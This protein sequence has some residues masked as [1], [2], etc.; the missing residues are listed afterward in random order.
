MF[1]CTI[2]IDTIYTHMLQFIGPDSCGLRFIR[3][4]NYFVYFFCLKV[5]F[6]WHDL[7]IYDSSIF[8]S[9]HKR[10]RNLHTPKHFWV[11]LKQKISFDNFMLSQRSGLSLC[12]LYKSIL[13]ILQQAYIIIRFIYFDELTSIILTSK[14][15]FQVWYIVVK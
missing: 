3:W 11:E 1:K 15:P 14:I 8:F 9:D 7:D 5:T 4:D 10:T 2:T 12:I 6:N 13:N